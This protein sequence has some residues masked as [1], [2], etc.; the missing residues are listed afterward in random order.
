MN[1]VKFGEISARNGGDNPELSLRPF[2]V[3]VCWS[4][5]VA[6]RAQEAKV[7]QPVVLVVPVNVVKF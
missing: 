1:G 4:Q 3:T 5:R 2:F 7:F 6:V